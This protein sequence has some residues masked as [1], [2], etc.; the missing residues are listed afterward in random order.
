VGAVAD[1]FIDKYR[2]NVPTS[3]T[4]M[5]IS[6]YVNNAMFCF[7]VSTTNCYKKEPSELST[8]Q[9]QQGTKIMC[10]IQTY[11]LL[12]I[13]ASIAISHFQL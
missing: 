3:T 7:S 4:M 6:M 11:T 8:V 2:G 9:Q 13:H 1:T 12:Q 5:K 10:K